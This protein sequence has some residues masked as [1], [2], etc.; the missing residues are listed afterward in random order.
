MRRR[1]SHWRLKLSAEL[2]F[3]LVRA[4]AGVVAGF[5]SP[6][7]SP[8]ASPTAAAAAAAA[9]TS[10]GPAAVAAA[11]SGAAPGVPAPPPLWQPVGQVAGVPITGGTAALQL[12]TPADAA[13][14]MPVGTNGNT[15][16]WDVPPGADGGGAPGD[17]L[18]SGFVT[19][20]GAQPE[21]AGPSS[22]SAVATTFQATAVKEEGRAADGDNSGMVT[23]D[24]HAAPTPGSVD[25]TGG[26]GSPRSHPL[27]LPAGSPS[28]DA[29]GT[30]AHGRTRAGRAPQHSPAGL[31]GRP[32]AM[33]TVESAA[34]ALAMAEA[35]EI[36]ALAEREVLSGEH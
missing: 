16:G 18:L 10:Q 20:V 21:A 14:H 26:R 4:A 13:L 32:A 11:A 19:P 36:A 2:G 22:F 30:E 5:G 34:A 23:G 7:P 28:S 25:G 31:E 12:S 6:L 9:A 33:R 3:R 29:P 1:P 8:A 15:A 27:D 35:A 17:Q 24:G